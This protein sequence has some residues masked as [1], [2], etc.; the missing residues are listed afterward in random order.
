MPGRW[1]RN[2]GSEVVL[3]IALRRRDPSPRFKEV[4]HPSAR[5]WTHHLEVRS[6]VDLDPPVEAWLRE[7]YESAG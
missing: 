5:L 1:L 2:P 7:A 6:P 4:A 3:S